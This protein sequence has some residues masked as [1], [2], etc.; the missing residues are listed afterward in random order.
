[1]GDALTK[2]CLLGELFVHVKRISV[3][4]NLGEKINVSL[5]D[6]VH[7]LV[8]HADRHVFVFV[9]FFIRHGGYVSILVHGVL[10]GVSRFVTKRVSASPISR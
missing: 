8:R 4:R 10:Q 5:G 9:A 2:L 3:A 7:R 6:G 1:M